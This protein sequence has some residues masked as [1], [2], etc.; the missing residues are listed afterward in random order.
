[1]ELIKDTIKVDSKVDLGRHKTF[2]EWDVLVPDIKEDVFE[3]VKAEGYISLKKEDVMDGKIVLRGDLNYN[4]IYLTQDKKVVSL[5]GKTDFNQAIEKEFVKSGMRTLL[6]TE[7]E[8][9][10]CNI[11][12]ERKLKLGAVVNVKG[13]LFEREKIDIIRQISELEDI[14]TY[15]EEI[16][17]E[18]II[19]I[20]TGEST[21]RE[22]IHLEENLDV[23]EVISLSPKVILKET[24]ISD[25]KLILGGALELYPVFLSKE[26]KIVKYS[27]KSIDFTQFV[28]VPG[29]CEGMRDDIVL[30]ISEVKFNLKEE[31]GKISLLEIESTIRSKCKVSENVTKEILKDAYCPYRKL[32]LEGK[33]VT[34]SKVV[35]SGKEEFLIKE[36]IQNDRDDIQ[37][38]EILNVTSDLLV[39]ENI[40][41][42]GKNIIEGIISV[43]IDYV[44]EEA[45]RPIYSIKEEI[46]FKYSID[47][48]N[49][50]ETMV[51]YNKVYIKDINYNL[52]K[53]EIELQIKGI[54]SYEVQE[55]KKYRF[56]VSG[57]LQETLDNVKRASIT[58][59]VSK[60]GETLWDVA[61][62]YN[63]TLEEIASANDLEVNSVLKE[64][65]CL[66]IEKK[67][68]C[69]I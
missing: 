69:E 6:D 54:C 48:E 13:H 41:L 66:I 12:N 47:I 20:E 16:E 37:I 19:G 59:Y 14:Q 7:I 15:K 29:A 57:E 46:P 2:L 53:G 61:K 51:P 40:I 36:T 52:L 34:L 64:G 49:C 28:E 67:V 23:S 35:S 58:I 43:N 9:I 3:I 22:T 38:K 30:N 33:D 63:A 62:R 4:I 65:Q 50:Q 21:V 10:D 11:T 56:L 8:H 55:N 31:D 25:N 18:N 42:E 32:K 24:R 39:T 68:V 1:M 45:L 44:P 26:G 5:V 60:E 17:Y 27:N